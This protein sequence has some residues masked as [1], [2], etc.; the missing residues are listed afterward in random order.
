MSFDLYVWKSPRDLDSERCRR[1]DPR[2]GKRPAAIRHRAPSSRAPTSAGSTASSCNDAP[3]LAASSDATPT[4][5]GGPVWLATKDE[6]PARVVRVPVTSGHVA[7]RARRARRHLPRSTT[8][9]CSTRGPGA[10]R[11][12]SRT[13]PPTPARHSGPAARSRPPSPAASVASSPSSRGS[14]GSPCSAASSCVVGGFLVVMA[15]FTFVHEGRKAW[16]ARR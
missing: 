9:S 5:G 16:Q 14:S 11:S 12:R 3:G 10:C 4:P 7:R 15:V 1:D 6:P 8:S 13:W 2:S